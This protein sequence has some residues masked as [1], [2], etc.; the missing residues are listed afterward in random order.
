MRLESDPAVLT[1]CERPLTYDDGD[2]RRL[3][4][5]WVRERDQKALLVVGDDLAVPDKVARAT[6]ITVRAVSLAELAAARIWIANRERMLPCMITSR[7]CLADTLLK[8]V[9]CFISEPMQYTH[10][11]AIFAREPCQSRCALRS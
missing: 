5:F 11:T 7:A 2:E 3:I 6:S 9:A 10:K 1:F 8:S 4:D